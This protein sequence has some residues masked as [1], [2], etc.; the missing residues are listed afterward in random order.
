MTMQTK[1]RIAFAL[2]G[3]MILATLFLARGKT[4]DLRMEAVGDMAYLN[5]TTDRRSYGE[6]KSFLKQNPG[7]KHL[8][9]M[10]MPGTKHSRENLRLARLIRKN[11]LSTHLR[12]DSWIASGAVDLFISGAKRTMECGAKIGVH[13]WSFNG[14]IGPDDIGRDDQRSIH[15][16]FL[17]DMGVDPRFY[18]FTREA[19][20]PEDIYV[21][22]YNEIERFGLLTQPAGC[23]PNRI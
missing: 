17:S 19:A 5:G 22:N 16:N 2:V 15:E 13:S 21:L 3:L 12:R 4:S 1:T 18:V 9:L 8:V 10:R 20:G 7:V 6:M 23:D 14:N 11:G